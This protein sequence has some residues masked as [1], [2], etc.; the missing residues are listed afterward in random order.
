MSQELSPHSSYRT[1]DIPWLPET[2]S[3]WKCT[4]VKY[5]FS[6]RVEKGYPEEPLLAATQT[7]GVVL[8]E[9]YENRTVVAMKDLHLLKLVE[10]GDFVISLR[11]FQG[12]IEFAHCRGIISPAYTVL[13]PGLD[14]HPGFY[15]YLFKCKPFVHS[16]TLYV[17][18]I[19]EGQNI[20][21]GRFS[22]SDLPVP[23][24]DEQEKIVKFLRSQDR[25]ILRF[26]RNK[27]SLL[28]LLNE[29]KRIL[30]RA[31]VSGQTIE[32]GKSRPSEILWLD[33]IPTDWKERRLGHFCS[34]GNGST[35]SRSEPAYWEEGH[36]PWLN[37]STVNKGVIEEADQFVTD[38][39]LVKCHLPIVPPGSVLVAITGQGKTRGMCALLKFE[40]TINQHLA[41]I[42]IRQPFVSSDYLKLLLTGFYGELRAISE[43][44][45][46]T[47]GALTCFDLRHLRVPIPP[48]PEQD[49][50][51]AF[52]EEQ[53]TS[54]DEAINRTQQEIDLMNEY[55]S[56]LIADAVTGKIDLRGVQFDMVED[57]LPENN[58]EISDISFE[59]DA[60]VF[61]EELINA[62]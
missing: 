45:G 24:L 16:M 60:E 33:R 14:I 2:P 17:T 12:G 59:Q 49:K 48:R 40:A 38:L 8:K 31:L 29:Q 10:V 61:E 26:I 32:P 15:A 50:I 53:T 44:C 21:Y 47:K 23:P 41:Y 55:R 18:G 1:S 27:H 11:S 25:R 39:A 36:Y 56:R 57:Q 34:I 62:N 58:V 30:I 19:R 9:M 13:K 52:F 51:L 28:E 6:E 42:T 22:R 54:M 20:D 43:G 37:S 5:L 35:P 7:K 3:H 4:K 46:S